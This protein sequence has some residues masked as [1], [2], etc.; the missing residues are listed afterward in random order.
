MKLV[1]IQNDVIWFSNGAEHSALML[2]I[3][4]LDTLY[5][6]TYKDFCKQLYQNRSQLNTLLFYGKIQV[7][8][9]SYV[10]K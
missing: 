5:I 3:R 10:K 1:S 6:L 7:K 2:Y 4:F 8:M 9:L